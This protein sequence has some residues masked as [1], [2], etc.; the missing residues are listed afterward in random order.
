ME[1]NKLNLLLRT[2]ADSAQKA[3]EA[4]DFNSLAAM[5]GL[6]KTVCEA[7]EICAR[8]ELQI[9]SMKQMSFSRGRQ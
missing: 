7:V 5:V 8:S 2:M 3:I 6:I 1:I 9:E 4:K